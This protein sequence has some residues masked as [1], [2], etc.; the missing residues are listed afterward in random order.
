MVGIGVARDALREYLAEQEDASP[1][2][3]LI[4]DA[5]IEHTNTVDELCCRAR[6]AADMSIS[7]VTK[8]SPGSLRGGLLA[9]KMLT[10]LSLPSTRA[11]CA[12]TDEYRRKGTPQKNLVGEYIARLTTFDEIAGF[13]RV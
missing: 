9:V 11:K 4:R 2:L 8:L 10:E 1:T 13:G 3:Q 12:V 5:L 7:K 6:G